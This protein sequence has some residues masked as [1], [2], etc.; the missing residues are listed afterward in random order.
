M[1]VR[2]FFFLLLLTINLHAKDSSEESNSLNPHCYTPNNFD[3]GNDLIQIK[4]LKNKSWIENLFN[5]M[6]EFNES[7]INKDHRNVSNFKISDKYKKFFKS[8]IK[9]I[10]K[11][12]NIDCEFDAKIK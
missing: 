12:N 5:L 6:I 11:K 2:L 4:I 8:K 9:I 3:N 1:L 7:E 10:S